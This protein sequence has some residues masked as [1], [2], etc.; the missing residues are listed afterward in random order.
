L[1]FFSIDKGTSQNPL[2][3]PAEQK[4]VSNLNPVAGMSAQQPNNPISTP[5]GQSQSNQQPY[6]PRNMQ[7]LNQG[8]DIANQFKTQTILG[9]MKNP[10]IDPDK[11]V[12]LA[13]MLGSYAQRHYQPLQNTW[14]DITQGAEAAEFDAY[15]NPTGKVIR[16]VKE[17]E[18]GNG[19]TI[20]LSEDRDGYP[21]GTK[22][23]VVINKNNPNDIKIIGNAGSNKALEMKEGSDGYWYKRDAKA[24]GGQV[25][26][27]QIPADET[28]PK[29]TG[30]GQNK[31]ENKVISKED[32][33]KDFQ[34]EQ[35]RAP[36]N[37]EINTA[38][39]K[40]YWK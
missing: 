30:K 28:N 40:G 31:K 6:N 5:V 27:G 13:D 9:A 34:K 12:A 26:K 38:K 21:A 7:N 16:N 17:P 1:T 2:V 4:V 37:N 10:D 32:F 35:N 11:A 18:Y 3:S 25:P 23:D 8:L 33:I 39:Q 20:V 24:K 19:K 29:G 22:V 14:K 36:T 15:G